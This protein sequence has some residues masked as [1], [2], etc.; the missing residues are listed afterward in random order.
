GDLLVTHCEPQHLAALIHKLR[1]CG[2]E[3]HCEGKNALRVRVA[4]KLVA[5]NVTTEEYPGFA[6]D[7]QAQFMALATQTE[8]V[9]TIRETIFENRYIHASEMM[10]MGANILVEGNLA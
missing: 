4:R 9:S 7:M 10:R 6:T 1:E 8:G 2:V 3:I 5:A